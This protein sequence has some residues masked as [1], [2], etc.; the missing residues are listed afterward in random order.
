MSYHVRED[1]G[2]TRP[3]PALPS[4]PTASAGW[5]TTPTLAELIG[6]GVGVG[7]TLLIGGLLTGVFLLLAARLLGV[8]P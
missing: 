1:G 6:A 4:V 7:G 2:I 3:L 5:R 8:L